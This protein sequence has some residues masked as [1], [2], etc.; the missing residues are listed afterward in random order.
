[1]EQFSAYGHAL[2]SLAVVA[3]FA[4]M[5]GPMSAMRKQAAGLDAGATPAADYTDPAFRLHRAYM[6][7][8]ENYGLFAGVT[9]AAILAGVSPFWVNLLATIFLVSRLVVAFVHIKGIGR[10]HVGPRSFIY[11][12]GW[13][14]NIVMAVLTI[15]AVFA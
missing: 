13:L 3:I 6:N 9:M 11:V 15:V 2:V 4:M 5:F 12:T 7:L 14:A 1:M 8:T 10:Q